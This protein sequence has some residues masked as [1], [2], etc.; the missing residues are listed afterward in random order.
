MTMT[1][2]TH[3]GCANNHQELSTRQMRIVV[4][5]ETGKVLVEKTL[6]GGSNNI[7]ELWAVAEA[8]LFGKSR[9]ILEVQIRTNSRNVLAW[10][11][12]RIGNN[13]ND[14]DAVV[15]LMDTINKLRA[16]VNID[17]T[18]IP[19]TENLAGMYIRVDRHSSA[20]WS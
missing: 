1:L 11:D 2:F 19:K 20:S 13:L 17:V 18:W 5:D 10:L 6:K 9:G 7:A 8:M 15:N 14:R 12:G 16:H 3:G 4:A